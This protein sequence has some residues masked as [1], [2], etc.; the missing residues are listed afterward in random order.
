MTTKPRSASASGNDASSRSDLY[1]R[2]TGKIIADLEQGVRPWHRP[3]NA[4][5]LEGRIVRPL[6]HNGIPYQGINTIMLWMAAVT[7]GYGSAFWFTFRQAKELGGNV[8]KGEHGELVVYADRITRTETND[9]GEDVERAIPFLKGYT[10]FNAEQCENLPVHYTAKIETS[11]LPIAQRIEA[12][13]RFFA[14]TGAEIRHGGNSAY[15]AEGEDF[16]QMPP[17]ETFRDAESYAA[18]LAHECVHWTKHGKRLAR[19]FG[20]T[21]FGDEGYAKEELVAELGSAFICAD[22]EI[23]PDIR[24]D[25]AAYIATWLTALKND[26]RLT[27]TAASHAQR[28]SDY[29]HGLQGVSADA[30]IEPEAAAA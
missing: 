26:T 6:R 7:Q 18:V 19:D 10:V 1:S 17:F 12:A 14:A 22:L 25:H 5:N 16:V 8:R 3:W 13:D 27:F 21:R 30:P 23:T 24:D 29:L 2:I 4:G 28:A 11:A 20:R 9:K 15:Y